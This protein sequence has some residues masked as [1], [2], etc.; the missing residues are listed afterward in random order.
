MKQVSRGGLRV[1]YTYFR[2][3]WVPLARGTTLKGG[4]VV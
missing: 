3:R 2:S 4:M 1:V